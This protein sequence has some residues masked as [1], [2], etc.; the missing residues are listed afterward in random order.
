MRRMT[1]PY[2]NGGPSN[3]LGSGSDSQGGNTFPWRREPRRRIFFSPVGIWRVRRGSLS[4]LSTA[5]TV[6]V[7]GAAAGEGEAEI[8]R[9][10]AMEINSAHFFLKRDL[11]TALEA[12]LEAFI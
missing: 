7:R 8:F 2:M 6:S 3:S 1:S 12:C 10:S 11:S 5:A 9:P 4:L